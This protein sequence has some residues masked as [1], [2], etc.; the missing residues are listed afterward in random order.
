MS[1]RRDSRR[2]WSYE[3]QRRKGIDCDMRET[4]HQK[5]ASSAADAFQI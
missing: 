4:D 5:I 1:K 2:F 3:W